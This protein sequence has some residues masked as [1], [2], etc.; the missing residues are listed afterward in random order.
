MISLVRSRLGIPGLIAI[1]ALVFAMGGAA[2]AA[3]KY[4]ITS[5]K[6]IKPSVLKQLKGKQGPQGPQGPAGTNGTNGKDGTNGAPGAPG[7]DGNSVTLV[8]EAPVGCL[9]GG[10]TYEVEGSNEEDEVCNGER[11]TFGGPL[12]AGQTETGTWGGA[13]RNRLSYSEN[14]AGELE[15]TTSSSSVIIPISFAAPVEPAPEP[16]YVNLAGPAVPGCPGIVDGLATAESG[17]LCVYQK[18]STVETSALFTPGSQFNE[19]TGA[20]AMGTE[21]VFTCSASSCLWAGVWAVTP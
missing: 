4:V 8:N 12:P 17:K 20:D 21:M 19:V 14:E 18:F 7:A 16:L 15:Q 11:G 6:Q 9:E 1:I 3:K 10:F 2:Y 13:A 5:T